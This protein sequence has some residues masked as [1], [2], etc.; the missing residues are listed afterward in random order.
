MTKK[1]KYDK[2]FFLSLNMQN[3]PRPPFQMWNVRKADETSVPE[4]TVA[5]YEFTLDRRPDSLGLAE[6]SSPELNFRKIFLPETGHYVVS[7]DFSGQELRVLANL[8]GEQAWIDTFLTGGDIHKRTAVSIWGEE[9]FDGRK[10]NMAKAINFGLAYGI[11]AKGLSAQIGTSEDEAQSYIDAFFKTH[12]AID[13][14]LNRQ[15]MEAGKTK[16]IV[17]HYGRKRRMHNYINDWGTLDNAGKRRSYNTPIQSMGAEIT[18]IA[19][20]K[21]YNNILNNPKYKGK[22]L[23]MSTIHDEINLSVPF[24]LVEEISALMDECMVHIIAPGLPVPIIT[25]L[26]IGHSMGLIWTFNQDP[27]T[28]VLEPEIEPYSNTYEEYLKDKQ[29]KL[30]TESTK[31]KNRE[32]F[33]EEDE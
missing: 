15:A 27:E 29:A 7:R 11:G 17:N 25:G 32:R 16:E 14:Y 19:L 4:Y 33:E 12:P 31:D 8:S 30:K 5:G 1:G 9:N 21:I 22:V 20:I 18:K 2:S 23:W 6:G 13:R 3:P 10:R 26:D 24:E 28:K